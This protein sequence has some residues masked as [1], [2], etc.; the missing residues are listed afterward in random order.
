MPSGF[1]DEDLYLSVEVSSTDTNTDDDSDDSTGDFG[2]DI[3]GEI[4]TVEEEFYNTVKQRL[5]IDVLI[6]I[7]ARRSSRLL[8]TLVP[9]INFY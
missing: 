8:P 2:E 5:S 1:D 3:T 7:I 6:S 9:T 4:N